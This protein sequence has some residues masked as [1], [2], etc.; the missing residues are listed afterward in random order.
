MAKIKMKT[1]HTVAETFETFLLSK[2]EKDLSE[3]T[4][5]TYKQHM[6]AIGKHISLA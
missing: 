2:R 4:L 6:A 5:T 3:K 1:G